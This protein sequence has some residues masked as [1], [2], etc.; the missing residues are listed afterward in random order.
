MIYDGNKT[1]E[2]PVKTKPTVINPAHCL[3]VKTCIERLEE[4]VDLLVAKAEKFFY[5]CEYSKCLKIL[6]E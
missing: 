6:D 5:N 1:V 4:S 2:T 3:S